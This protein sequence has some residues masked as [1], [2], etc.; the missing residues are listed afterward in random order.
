MQ[1]FERR[2]KMVKARE[3]KSWKLVSPDMMSEEEAEGDDFVRHRPSWRSATLNRF[4]EKLEN[5]YKSKHEKTLAKPRRYGNPVQRE[6]PPGIPSWM[7]NMAESPLTTEDE[8]PVPIQS[9]EELFSD[10]ETSSTEDDR[11]A[12]DLFTVRTDKH[13]TG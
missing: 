6:A 7:L 4:F 9:D 1:I 10:R 2:S 3:A 8:E 13:Y 11:T 12:R 5:R